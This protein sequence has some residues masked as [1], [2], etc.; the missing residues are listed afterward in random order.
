MQERLPETLAFAEEAR[1]AFDVAV[2]L[3][4]GGSSLAPEVFR[5][6]SGAES[7][8]VLDTTHPAAVRRLA[9]SL[10]TERTLF[11]VSSKSGT[12]LETRS[13]LD[14]FWELARGRGESFA[15]ITD[16]GS[17][18]EAVAAERGFRAVFHGEPTIGGRYSALSSSGWCPPRS[19][20][21]T[22]TSCWRARAWRSAAAAES[23]GVELGL[24]LGA[25]WQEG[26][27]K[28]VFA[29]PHGFGLWVEQLL[30]ES[31]GKQGKGLV[32]APERPGRPDRQAAEVTWSTA[33]APSSTGGRSP[34]PRPAPSSAS[35]PS[36]SPTSRRRRTTPRMSFPAMAGV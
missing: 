9:E 31:T 36:T 33:S 10:D 7:F 6:A 17:E 24:A 4:M 8:H 18:L 30:A 23:P 11:L 19:W 26:R 5:R 34:S 21:S 13:H 2:L 20:A 14:F 32:P 12:T 35:T 25:G 3:G 16:P 29:N 15:A 27:D 1:G 28:V 22:S